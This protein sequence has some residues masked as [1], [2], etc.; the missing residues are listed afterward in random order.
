MGRQLREA[1]LTTSGARAKL[2][3]G[4]HWRLLDRDAHLGYRRGKRGGVWVARWRCGKGY[5]QAPIG[6]ADDLVAEGSMD[7]YAAKKRAIEVIEE[8]RRSAAADRAGPALT[9]ASAV[10]AYVRARD[11]REERRQGRAVRSD[12]GSRLGR[13]VLGQDARGRQK[14]VPASA[15][16]SM[17]LDTLKERDL[18]N[19]RSGLPTKLKGTTQQRLINDLKA[20][21]NAAYA[22]NR[23]RLE[24]TLPGIIKHGLRSLAEAD[25]A[26][27]VARDSQ[28]LSDVEISRLVHAAQQIDAEQNWDGDLFR[29]VLLLAATGARF[30]QVKRMVVGDCQV[31]EQR[32]LVP[33]SRKGRGSKVGSIT[34][35][36]GK[37]VVAALAVVV[38]DR[39][40]NQ[41]LLERWRSVQ[42][43]RID[44]ER[45]RRGPWLSSAE[46]NRPWRA[47]RARAGMPTV[48]PYA[49]R[50]SSIV[51]GIRA[52]LPIRLVAALHDT[53]TAMIERHYS[54]WIT[55]GLEDMARAAIV[56]LVTAREGS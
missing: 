4:V 51:K 25:D 3:P 36:I 8:A 2:L 48:I 37:D 20:A 9:V 35:P 42:I 19:W 24:P 26:E 28:I 17:P 13:Y 31:A 53:S 22:S 47:I 14:L 29:L 15:I 43:S 52:N 38:A 50:H 30:S 7:F 49:L 41:P 56:P 34:I 11:A 10:E 45:D 23:D 12:A 5:R 46:M 16:A 40:H 39:K 55:S 1:P 44:W 33:A 18:L 32:L 6:V 54:K 27:P 21:L